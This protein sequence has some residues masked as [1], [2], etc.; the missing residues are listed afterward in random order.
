[1][2]REK[3]GYLEIER[4]TIEAEEAARQRLEGE[5][6]TEEHRQNLHQEAMSCAERDAGQKIENEHNAK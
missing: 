1:M 6:N 4:A 3:Q 2:H 5:R